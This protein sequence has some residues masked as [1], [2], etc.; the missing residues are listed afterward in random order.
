MK[1]H[2]DIR[3]EDG[4]EKS[5]QTPTRCYPRFRNEDANPS[6]NLRRSANIY[7]RPWPR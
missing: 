5:N 2:I 6:E 7:E 4:H 3:G 1:S